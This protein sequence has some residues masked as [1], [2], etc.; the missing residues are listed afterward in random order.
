MT[1]Y[2]IRDFLFQES[3]LLDIYTSFVSTVCIFKRS[4]DLANKRSSALNASALDYKS[5][6]ESSIDPKTKVPLSSLKSPKLKFL[7]FP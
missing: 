5:L 4:W 1:V 2:S 6:L 7:G 3:L